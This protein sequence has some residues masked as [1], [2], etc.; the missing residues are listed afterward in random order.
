MKKVLFIFFTIFCSQLIFSISDVKKSF[1]RGNIVDKIEAVKEASE[2]ESLE[3]AFAGISF[4]TEYRPLLGQD[5]DLSA[6]AIASILKLPKNLTLSK[7][8]EDILT[9]LCNIFTIFTDENVKIAVLNKF[10]EF[11]NTETNQ[12]IV[13]FINNYLISNDTNKDLAVEKRAI[14]VVSKIGNAETFTIIYKKWKNG[15]PELKPTLD[16]ALISVSSKN[17]PLVVKIISESNI[18]EIHNYFIL[19]SESNEISKNFKAEIAEN[20]LSATINN[21]EDNI[22]TSIDSVALQIKVL[23]VISDSNWTKASKLAVRYFSIAKQ[24]YKD[25]LMSETQ[26][27][28][29]INCI[30]NL[31]STDSAKALSNYLAEMNIAVENNK[32]PAKSVVLATINSLGILGDKSA[33]D[34]LLYVTYL[35]YPED[36]KS[37]AREALAKLKW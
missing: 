6:L 32:I 20:V 12:K 9:H 14:E 16:K 27:V 21:K 3:L 17:L 18:T 13:P 30:T 4:V 29:V 33:F 1:I 31:A 11:S 24:E 8:S 22:E 35:N 15:V 36:V 34:N 19:I 37:N 25:K 26:F 7:Q 2:N 28:Q 5:R 10:D 23:Q